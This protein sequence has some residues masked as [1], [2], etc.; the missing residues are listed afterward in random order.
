MRRLEVPYRGYVIRYEDDLFIAEASRPDTFVL[1]LASRR[2]EIVQDAIDHLWDA[3]MGLAVMTGW[4]ASWIVQPRHCRVRIER[5]G[6]TII[7]S[8]I[9]PV[10][11]GSAP[12]EPEAQAARRPSD[13]LLHR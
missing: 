11:S 3:T 5:S 6:A 4:L 2:L 13:I 9:D 12:A 1:E 8:F 7:G 10:V